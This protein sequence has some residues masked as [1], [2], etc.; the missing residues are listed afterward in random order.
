[1]RKVRDIVRYVAPALVAVFVAF[2][3]LDGATNLANEASRDAGEGSFEVFGPS[4]LSEVGLG[5]CAASIAVMVRRVDLRGVPR[6]WRNAPVSPAAGSSPDGRTASDTD[7]S[8]TLT[9]VSSNRLLCRLQ[10]LRI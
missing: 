10:V 6:H 3:V 4:G 8:A 7:P 9:R 2:V 1:M 5:L